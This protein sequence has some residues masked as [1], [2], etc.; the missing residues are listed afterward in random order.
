MTNATIKFATDIL[1]RLGEELNP[2]PDQG[3]IELVKNS[4]DADALNCRIELFST[5]DAGG[6]I[7]IF[8]DGDGMTESEIIDGWLVLGRSSKSV[9]RLTRLNRIPAGNKGL[10]RL[11]ALRMGEGAALSTRPRGCN[12]QYDLHID[13]ASYDDVELVDEVVLHIQETH[14]SDNDSCGTEILIENLRQPVDRSAVKR[15]ARALVLLADPFGDNPLGFKPVLVASE[16]EDLEQL[17]EKRYFDEAEYVLR[18]MV[19]YEGFASASVTDWRGN[20]IFSAGHRDLSASRQYRPYSCPQAN[21]D[22]WLFILSGEAFSTRKVT[23]G[24]VRNWLREFG[25]VHLYENGL[26]VMPY[27]N[28][29]NDWLDMNL[30][31][32]RSPEERPSTNNS[33]GRVSIIS[34]DESLIQKTDRSGFV[35]TEAFRELRA[36]AQDALD[37]MARRRNEVAEQRRVKE[38]QE[39]S[40]RVDKNLLDV[41]KAI[42]KI[43]IPNKQQ[44]KESF[45]R[46]QKAKDLEVANLRKEVQLYRTL[47]T[48]GITAATFAHESSG[49]PIKVISMSIKAVERRAKELLSSQYSTRLEDP[50]NK[51]KKAVDALAVLGTVTLALIQHEKRRKGSVNVHE[52][53]E[54]IA[55][56][57]KPFLEGRS[58]ELILDFASEE[59]FIQGSDAA[60]ESI[61]TNLLNNSLS[62][63]ESHYSMERRIIITTASDGQY[64]SI[65][66]A[67]NGPGI[68]DINIRDIW[69]PGETTRLNG[70]GL[71]LTIV[72]DTVTDLGGKVSAK[73]KGGLGGAEVVVQI[74]VIGE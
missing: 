11:A 29:G 9:K 1:R 45:T 24:E 59:L 21:F 8:D 28:P 64:L 19:D 39:A 37:W 12:S 35:E 55:G 30:Q 4:Y 60:L 6:S 71:G 56:T 16:F 61:V 68:T 15:L 66:V 7:L 13:W 42:E 41:D 31:R 2:T 69:L 18:A 25:G 52:V 43:P 33:I 10:G 67:D 23:I 50:I 49:N 74:P 3:I 32:A 14:L 17:V 22:L 54:G 20:T 26:R 65:H 47:S 57:F 72:K 62:A 36:F 70:T 34:Q 38:R 40:K 5:D 73:A 44:L 46:Y 53:I 51:I 58:V 48:A 27:G 63:F